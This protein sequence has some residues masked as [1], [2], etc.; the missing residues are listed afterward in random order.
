MRSKLC[1]ETIDRS[2]LPVDGARS[3]IVQFEIGVSGG[4]GEDEAAEWECSRG[5][6]RGGQ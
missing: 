4:C 5:G 1:I 3:L 6:E 2:A